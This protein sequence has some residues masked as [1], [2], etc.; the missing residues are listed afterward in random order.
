MKYKLESAV[1]NEIKK[2]VANNN[3]EKVISMIK[4]SLKDNDVGNA[5]AIIHYTI[6]QT[7]LNPADLHLLADDSKSI[8]SYAYDNS[9]PA[10]ANSL[11]GLCETYHYIDSE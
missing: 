6:S 5:F 1:Q 7:D 9:D 2:A 11:V 4:D 3:T 10:A 8:I